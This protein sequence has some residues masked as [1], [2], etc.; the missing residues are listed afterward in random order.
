MGQLEEDY[1]TFG[2]ADVVDHLE[3]RYLETVF[4]ELAS[5]VMPPHS[6]RHM[7]RKGRPRAIYSEAARKWVHQY[8]VCIPAPS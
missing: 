3:M 6:K 1:W 7:F 8:D 5:I 4:L 2:V